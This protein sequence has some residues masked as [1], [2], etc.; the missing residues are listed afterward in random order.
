MTQQFI[1]LSDS[2]AYLTPVSETDRPILMAVRGDRHTLLIDGGNSEAHA[3]LFLQHLKEAGFPE[4]TLT[5]VT[6]WHW[7][8]IFGLAALSTPIISSR[9]TKKAM[10][11]LVD[12]TWDDQAIDERVAS[13]VEIEFCA[14]AIKEEFQKERDIRIV[15]PDVLFADELTLDLGGMTCVLKQV[16]GDHAEDS[17]VVYVKEEKLLFLADCTAQKMYAPKWYYDAV[18]TVK[19]LDTLDQFDAETYVYSHW[20][21]ATKEEFQKE[22]TLLR[23]LAELVTKYEGNRE[24]MVRALEVRLERSPEEEE[25]EVLDY[26]VNGW[27]K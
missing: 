25:L 19:L 21:P 4:P 26:F 5:V 2:I 27:H 15:L 22:A 3:E 17:V 18:N 6:H 13:G 7:D 16:G 12:F 9:D 23:T 1:H 14:K 8:H 10:E 24:E 11:E 20:K